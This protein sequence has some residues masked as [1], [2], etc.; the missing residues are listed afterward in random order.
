MPGVSDATAA[1]IRLGTK[2]RIGEGHCRRRWRNSARRCPFGS[3]Q[4]E[5]TIFLSSL[6]ENFDAALAML[7]DVLL[8]PTFPQDELDKWKTRQRAQLEQAKTQ[9]GFPGERSADQAALSAD[10]RRYTHPTV[11][12]LNKITRDSDRRALQEVLRALGR[13]GGHRGRHHAEGRRR[14]ARQGAGRV[15]G[16]ARWRT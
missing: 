4:G 9:P 14:Q 13:V 10:A 15:E 6:T 3:G 5:A 11:E 7:A 1:L 8:N 12:A 2:T 16:R